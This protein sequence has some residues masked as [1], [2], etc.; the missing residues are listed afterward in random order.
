MKDYLITI[1]CI[2][3]LGLF[4]GGQ[5]KTSWKEIGKLKTRDAKDIKSSSWSIGGET[6]DRDYTDYQSYKKYLGPLG[7]KRIRLQGGWSKCE[8]KKGEYN[9]AWLD[10]IIPDAA[11]RGV[12]PW[13]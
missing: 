7:A 8:K 1:G 10:S 12:Y 13:V 9:F 6:L 3:F 11:S 2:L 4:A 5:Q